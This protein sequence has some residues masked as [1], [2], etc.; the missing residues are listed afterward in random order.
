MTLVSS[1]PNCGHMP[2]YFAYLHGDGTFE[3][4]DNPRVP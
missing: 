1:Q 2:A 3:R 4:R